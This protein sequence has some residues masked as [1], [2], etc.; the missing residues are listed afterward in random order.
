MS[1]SLSLSLS[2]SA[3]GALKAL[4]VNY[5]TNKGEFRTCVWQDDRE[6]V[7][8]L[9]LLPMLLPVLLPMVLPMVMPTVLPMLLPMVR[10]TVLPATFRHDLCY[11]LDDRLR[12]CRH[13]CAVLIT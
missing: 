5:T 7:L 8:L 1:L 9:L 4:F 2:L 11:R 10:P 3:T 13:G 6:E 12:R